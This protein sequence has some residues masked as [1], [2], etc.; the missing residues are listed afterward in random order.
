MAPKLGGHSRV[1]KLA[2]SNLRFLLRV[3]NLINMV[4]FNFFKKYE[5]L[6][7][8]ISNLLIFL[9]FMTNHG[10]GPHKKLEHEARNL[11]YVNYISVYHQLEQDPTDGFI[12]GYWSLSTII[13]LRL[14]YFFRLTLIMQIIIISFLTYAQIDSRF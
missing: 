14:F 2:V 12:D 9:N 1:A 6:V 5:F 7:P 8:A 10:R 4:K 3:N 13:I 11:L